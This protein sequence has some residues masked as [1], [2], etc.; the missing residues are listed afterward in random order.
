ML[1]T[2]NNNTYISKDLFANIKNTDD[3]YKIMYMSAE[4]IKKIKEAL[5]YEED[6]KNIVFYL[7]EKDC[8]WKKSYKTVQYCAYDATN[9]YLQST[10][11]IQLSDEDK[12]WYRDNPIIKSSGL[13]Q[14]YTFTVLNDLVAP[15]GIGISK[16]FLR[17][18]TSLS[19]DAKEWTQVLGINPKALVDRDCSN[20]EYLEIISG[21]NDNLKE[22]MKSQVEN[23]NFEF[24]DKLKEG[25]YIIFHSMSFGAVA[26]GGGHSI[27]VG[28]RNKRN[29]WIVAIKMD[30]LENIKY[31]KVPPTYEYSEID[32]NL[33][34]DF[35]ECT[36]SNGIKLDKYRTYI[37]YT[38]YQMTDQRSY[39]GDTDQV[40]TGKL[41]EGIEEGNEVDKKRW[42]GLDYWGYG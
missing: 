26:T 13:P 2:T 7:E 9:K 15:Y 4:T 10:L 3:Y 23:Y 32:T 35:W 24:T 14:E 36:D 5:D 16:I 31:L 29:D 33:E 41:I 30:R 19:K 42:E 34:L 25:S 37:N 28:P 1:V 22:S 39:R 18:K 38:P 27:Y 17:K 6:D 20:Q 12:D 21:G 8:K 11:G 40:N